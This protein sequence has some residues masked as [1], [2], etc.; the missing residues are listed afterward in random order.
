MTTGFARSLIGILDLLYPHLCIGCEVN[1]VPQKEIFCVTCQN[2]T[3]ITTLHKYPVN[4]CSRRIPSQ[5]IYRAASMFRF[6]PGGVIQKIIHTIKYRN[7]PQI[8]HRIGRQYAKVI[9][10]EEWCQ[11]IDVI[12]PVPLHTKRL[13]RRGFNQSLFFARGLAEIFEKPVV[14]G[15]LVRKLST[16]TQTAK[17]RYQRL[18]NMLDA[19]ECVD[20]YAFKGKH[21]LLVDDVLTTGATIEA[22]LSTLQQCQNIKFSFLT[23]AIAE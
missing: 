8:A 16:R 20:P 4:E 14:K 12:V 3:S 6:F 17:S 22:C 19:F 11:S 18:Q 9:Q 13:R 5:P 7:Q 2:K 15:K 21:I 23:I 10:G 1:C